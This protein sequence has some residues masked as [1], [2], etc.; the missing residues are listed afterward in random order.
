MSGSENYGT[1]TQWN[2]T[3]QK[4]GKELQPFVTAWMELGSVK[5]SEISQAM[6]IKYHMM[7]PISGTLSSKQTS[8]HNITRHIEIKNKLTVTR[9]DRG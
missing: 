9:R 3:K 4:E 2:T 1:F 8:K 6:K 5:A 7:P